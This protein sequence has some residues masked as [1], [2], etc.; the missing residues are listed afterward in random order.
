[1]I[2]EPEKIDYKKRN[3]DTLGITFKRQKPISRRFDEDISEN[4]RMLERFYVMWNMLEPARRARKRC[5]NF[6]DGDQWGDTFY[7]PDS[8]SYV[9][10][11]DYIRSQGRV[12]LVQNLI[13]PVIKN[14]KGQY[15]S[16]AMKGAVTSRVREKQTLGYTMGAALDAELNYNQSVELDAQQVGEMSLSGLAIS[17]VQWGYDETQDRDGLLITN[18][19]INRMMFN[20]DIEDIRFEKSIRAIGEIHDWPIQKIIQMFART[21]KEE[22]DIRS[23]FPVTIDDFQ[24]RYA[25]FTA[26]RIDNLSFLMP[27]D[28]DKG[29]VF[30]LWEKKLV[31]RLKVKD[32]VDASVQFV[33]LSEAELESINQ[34]RINNGIIA[35][36][37]E[38]K[39]LLLSWQM[40]PEQVFYVKYLTA[41][42][43]CLFEA[44]SPY[45]HQSHPYII[46]VDSMTDGKITSLV[47]SMIPMQ[48]SLN[49]MITMRDFIIGNSAK[50]LL[51]IPEGAGS[52][53]M[54]INDFASEWTK[55]NGVIIY[56]P[57]ATGA[58]PEQITTNSV[59]IGINEQISLSMSLFF[60]ISG[61]GQAIQGQQ[62]R[63]G[64]PSSLY[65]QEAQNST[66]NIKDF[67]SRLTTH[68]VE[69]DYKA[70][71]LIQ[72]FRN[73]PYYI[74]VAGK[75]IPQEARVYEPEKI[76]SVKFDYNVSESQDT[77][78]FRQAMDAELM[79]LLQMQAIDV[80]LYLE[81]S[82][83]PWS[84]RLLDAITKREGQQQPDMAQIQQAAAQGE[85]QAIQQSD[86][87]AIQMMQQAMKQPAQGQQPVQSN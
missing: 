73:E 74:T 61:I 85:Q 86:P 83:M 10:G 38:E 84:D 19:T 72:Q 1:M 76:K 16:F 79:K 21:K 8:R 58:K 41:W 42:G 18:P 77:P 57:H 62:A 63:A 34:Q 2:L 39:I 65:A 70:I 14:L 52:T 6:V 60:Q 22:E 68:K 15:R 48:V 66:L 20:T 12:P 24:A 45:K 71:Q 32:P 4:K 3:S 64:T 50:G 28:Y 69:R 55:S 81:Q 5:R 25:A 36:V 87:R 80:K 13:L 44:E 35:G 40:K 11:D 54:N 47:E 33:S 43:Q 27:E 37:P 82:S 53:D 23:M 46:T 26:D 30:E 29:R 51:M 75:D 31:W 67:M 78:M 9:R 56:R 49:R 7:D 17:K 59:P